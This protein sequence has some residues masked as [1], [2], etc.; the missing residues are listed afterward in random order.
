MRCGEV[1]AAG[2]WG[3]ILV[4]QKYALDSSTIM[5][6]YVLVI[7]NTAYRSY[8]IVRGDYAGKSY[9]NAERRAGRLCP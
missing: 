8:R 5:Y 2:E 7:S 4:L 3:D 1:M 6:Y 9:R